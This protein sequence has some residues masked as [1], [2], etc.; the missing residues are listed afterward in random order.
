[1]R[2]N[3]W[4]VALLLLAHTTTSYSQLTVGDTPT[5]ALA[6]DGSFISWKEH[7][8]DDRLTSGVPFNGS[9][10]LEMA[11]LDRDGIDDIVSVH[12][13]DS[14][15]DSTAPG[16]TPPAMGHVRIAFG[17]NNPYDWTNITL[18][19]GADASA[20]EDAAIADVNGDGFL[21]IMVAA[22]LSHLIYFQNPGQD[23]RNRTWE[24]LI[25]PMTQ[26]RGSYI[27]VFLADL[28]GDG[29][30][31]AVAPNKGAQRP[32]IA[33]YRRSTPASIYKVTGDPLNGSNWQEIELGRFSNPRNSEP[34]DIDQ[35][36]DLDIIVGSNG[37][38][39]IILF[40]NIEPNNLNFEEH[41]IGVYGP[42]TNGFNMEFL[43]IN[44][45][46][47]LDIIGASGRTLTWFE[48]PEDVDHT[49]VSRSIGSFAPDSMTGFEIADIND[50]GLVDII[51]GSYS[52]GPRT[53]DGEVDKNDSLGRIGW[54]ENP[55]NIE[56]EWVRHD[57]SR[58]KRGMFDRFIARDLDNDGDID[59]VGT[60]G[61][62]DP[63]DGVFWLEQVR[64]NEALPAFQRARNEESEEVPLP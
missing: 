10:G 6:T 29:R 61:N 20:A 56:S 19:E 48:Q 63:Y 18:A 55:G 60:R 43:D 64:T 30:P 14:T 57:I 28:D 26:G 37:E 40:E 59:F 4:I 27:R 62:S 3:L 15:Y 41:A 52:R 39:R 11:D 32:T 42:R 22:E 12:E 49:W 53:G 45:D 33:D 50:D 9:D 35:D 1:M 47:R 46:G 31:E 23:I 24:R 38:N 7:I 21:D 34:I 8:I 16:E 17:S 25:L 36:G 13:S 54:F 51:A 2:K 44:N 5:R 58:R